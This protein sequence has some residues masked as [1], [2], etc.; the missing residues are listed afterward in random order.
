MSKNS[1]NRSEKSEMSSV[2]FVQKALRETIAPPSVGMV[3][4]RIRH[5]ARKTGWT[6]SRTRDAWYADPRISISAEELRQI[7]NTTGLRYGRQERR[8]IDALIARAD[9]LLD[10]PDADFYRPFT[11]AL[12]A[13]A[14]A[15]DRSGARR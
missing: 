6:Y 14:G 10:G 15:L 5:A 9:A 4:A 12:R 2:E 7:E 11:D 3:K 1:E 13:I 8:S